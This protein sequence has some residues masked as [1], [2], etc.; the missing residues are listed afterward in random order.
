MNRHILKRFKLECED[1]RVK[2]VADQVDETE[3]EIPPNLVLVQWINDVW[4]Y[5]CDT[6]L[7]CFLLFEMLNLAIVKRFVSADLK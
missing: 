6:C 4:C 7:L 1:D 5:P 2:N 3:A